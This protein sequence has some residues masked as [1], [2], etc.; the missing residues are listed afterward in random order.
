MSFPELSSAL[1]RNAE[2]R[3]IDTSLA[4]DISY[5]HFA[6]KC[7]LY[8]KRSDQNETSG[9]EHCGHLQVRISY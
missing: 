4:V 5:D 1:E 8:R 6:K 3:I 2:S 9:K 7:G